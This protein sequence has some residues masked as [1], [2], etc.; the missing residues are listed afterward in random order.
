MIT[1]ETSVL[2]ARENR[3]MFDRIREIEHELKKNREVMKAAAAEAGDIHNFISSGMTVRAA[4]YAL[5]LQRKLDV[6]RSGGSVL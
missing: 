3:K 2:I 6:E 5:A 4:H 1:E